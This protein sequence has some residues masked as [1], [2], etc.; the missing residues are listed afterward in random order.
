M[1]KVETSSGNVYDDLGFPDAKTMQAKAQIV[2]SM[3]QAVEAKRLSLDQVARALGAT[4]NELD[5]LLTGHFQAY[6]LGELGRMKK[7]IQK[8]TET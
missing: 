1:S 6:S 2:A 7:K 8:H 3:C 5:R 4:E